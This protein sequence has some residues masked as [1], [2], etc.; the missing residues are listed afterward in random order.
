MRRQAE[1]TPKLQ[2]IILTCLSIMKKP[3]YLRHKKGHFQGPQVCHYLTPEVGLNSGRCKLKTDSSASE[4][5]QS[6]LTCPHT[7]PVRRKSTP[8]AH[9]E[10]PSGSKNHL[11]KCSGWLTNL[12][13]QRIPLK[14]RPV[15]L[16][17]DAISQTLLSL[18][19]TASSAPPR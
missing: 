15:G 10:S 3:C 14:A 16:L 9:R 7:P 11:L 8:R 19:R 2:L 4:R 12:F 1:S 13:S 17:Q 6:H 18:S 5:A